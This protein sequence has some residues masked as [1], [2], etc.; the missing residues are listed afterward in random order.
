M[1]ATSTNIVSG[2][3]M[4]EDWTRGADQLTPGH[5]PRSVRSS[6]CS[7]VCVLTIHLLRSSVTVTFRGSR[8]PVRVSMLRNTRT[9][10]NLDADD[11]YGHRHLSYAVPLKCHT[12]FTFSR[13]SKKFF[14]IND[15]MG[16][17]CLAA[18]LMLFQE[19]HPSSKLG[20]VPLKT[21]CIIFLMMLPPKQSQKII[22][23]YRLPWRSSRLPWRGEVWGGESRISDREW[24]RKKIICL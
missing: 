10:K 5:Q 7:T 3:A 12:D 15:C 8:K 19:P 9:S 16:G 6:R 24:R 23:S 21:P 17:N 11:T 2:S 13:R 4:R 22:Q 1:P 20:D 14:K 18:A